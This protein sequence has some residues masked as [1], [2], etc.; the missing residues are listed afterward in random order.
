MTA[1]QVDGSS[2]L[3]MQDLLDVYF[4][5]Y[6]AL[7]DDDED[8]R[9]HAAIVTS[10]LLSAHRPSKDPLEGENLSLCPLVASPQLLKFL[11]E[12]YSTTPRLWSEAVQRLTGAC[13]SAMGLLSGAIVLRLLPV[14]GM[15]QE[16]MQ[17]DS[18]LFVEEKQNL[19]IDD[20]KEAEMW[21]SALRDLYPMLDLRIKSA[22]EIWASE[23]IFALT[24]IAR[25]HMDG[26][27]GWTSKPKVFT[28][29]M[30][31]LLTAKVVLHGADDDG[32][33][34]IATTCREALKSFLAVGSEK[35]VH[36]LWLSEIEEALG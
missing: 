26:A 15:L 36:E 18:S 34:P 19:F 24:A 4:A 30:R 14:Q 20:V 7:T 5:L 1:F 23:G 12:E 13:P 29:G 11:I 25:D 32:S 6:D 17:T 33:S 31:V 16:A 10:S 28:L 8:L 22:L 2:I 3:I 9:D 21:A 35:L 27:L